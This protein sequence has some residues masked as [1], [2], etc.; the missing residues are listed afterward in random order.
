MSATAVTTELSLRGEVIGPDDADYD[1]ARKIWNGCVDKR[2]ALIA[3]CRGVAD[4]LAALDY[5][6]DNDLLIAVRGGGHSIPGHSTCDGGIVIDLSQMKGIRVDPSAR[7]VR[8]EAGVTWGEF[9]R[10]THAFGLATTGGQITTTGIAGLTLGGGVGWLMRKHGLTCD[11]L[12]SVDVVTPDGRYVTA[13]EDENPE[14]F[15]GLRGGGGN[16]GIATSFEYRL[17]PLEQVLAGPLV[18]RLERAG[19]GLRFLRDFLDGAPDELTTFAVFA[20]CPPHEPFPAHLHGQPVFLI[21]PCWS[22]PQDEGERLLRPLR[23]FGPPEADLVGPLPYP[24]FQSMLDGTAPWGLRHYGK[25]DFLGELD[26]EA[27]DVLV[28]RAAGLPG[29]LSQVLIA[30][31]GGAVAR[32]S[33]DATAFGN[34]GA[35]F[36]YHSIV[37]WTD[38]EEDAD[39]IAWARSLW[40]GMRPHSAGVYVNFLAEDEGRLDEV[41]G[42][43]TFERLTAL[44]EEFDPTNALRLNHNIAPGRS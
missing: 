30:Q 43:R 4:V 26:D 40:Q 17:H 44:K 5:A 39:Q 13:S 9:D 16:F 32:V 23:E 14:L 15:W 3:R 7:T 22:G 8:A 31:L 6:R 33:P 35:G 27:I 37:L 25:S 24:I 18:H 20:T 19:E 10:E 11:N 21:V 28:D 41:Y 1:E 34:R 38:P 42:T 29:P 2:P 12:L 36:F